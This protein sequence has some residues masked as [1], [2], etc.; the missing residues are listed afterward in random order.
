MIKS[1]KFLAIAF[2]LACA[3]PILKAQQNT[4]NVV[5]I[6]GDDIA[7]STIGCYGSKTPHTSPNID[8][9]AKEGVLFRNM[10]VSEA[11]CAP[12]RAELY[13]GLTPYSSGC[14]V[15][16][17]ATK[18][19]TLSMAQRLSK[20]GYRVGI[21][22]KTHIKPQSVYPFE[23]IKGFPAGCTASGNSPVTWEGVTEFMT[24][25]DKQPFCL[26]IGSINAH[27]PW[28]AGDTS[29][30]KLSDLVLPP[31]L[32]DNDTTRTFFRE[33]I[34]EVRLFDEQ[35]GKL[36]TLLKDLKKDENTALIVLDE[37][38]IGMPGAKWSTYDIGVR[39]ACV[40]KWP[41]S[42][43]KKSF[44]TDAIAQYCD[45]LPTLMDAAGGTVPSDMD[46]KSLLPVLTGK[47]KKHRDN[48]YF[49]HNS[50]G[51]SS[52]FASRAITDGQY[53][54]IWTLTPENKYT[55][56]TINGFD[57]GYVDVKTKRHVRRVYKSWL[58]DSSSNEQAREIVN[59]YRIKPEIQ[60]FDLNADPYEMKNLADTPKHQ[61]KIKAMKAKLTAWM[62]AQKDDRGKN[63]MFDDATLTANKVKRGVNKKNKKKK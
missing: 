63:H 18:E 29:P 22:G 46:G 44:E 47:T 54:L 56:R 42:I 52:A 58:A 13:T 12:T 25:N 8:A 55:V 4:P 19:G 57:Y 1:S 16:H 33:Y 51:E 53:K 15:N 27:A 60:F 11:M 41:R 30:W 9:L 61:A 26:V 43:V 3:M 38:G 5:I 31:S 10:F 20:L 39:S 14:V 45:I 2:F 23:K 37:N 7:A 48:A 34:A 24:R 40:M 59:R 17:S 32:V 21:T 62:D 6:L 36:N 49:I 50:G 35:V 28:D